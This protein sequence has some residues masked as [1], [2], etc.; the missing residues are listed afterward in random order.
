MNG[1]SAFGSFAIGCLLV[2]QRAPPG[3]QP[4]ASVV[5]GSSL[6][7]APRKLP[8]KLVGIPLHRVE[9][10]LAVGAL[11][12]HRLHVVV[13]QDWRVFHSDQRVVVESVLANDPDT[14]LIAPH[15]I[16]DEVAVR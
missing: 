5:S 2:T 14:G 1:R 16:E 10:G 7:A 8:R 9:Y 11:Q 6:A 15:L 4:A 3:Y 13:D 12:R